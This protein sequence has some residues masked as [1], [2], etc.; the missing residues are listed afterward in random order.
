MLKI[1][2]LGAALIIIIATVS[3]GAYAYFNDVQTISGNKIAAG[4][5]ELTLGGD[6]VS[7]PLD[8]SNVQP[9]AWTT[10]HLADAALP[11]FNFD[12]KNTGTI[13]GELDVDISAI[14]NDENTR[15]SVELRSGDTTD[16]TN[17][18]GELGGLMKIAVWVDADK[19]G[20]WTTGDYYLNPA[21]PAAVY[22]SSPGLPDAAF[23]TVNSFD[24]VAFPK[25]VTLGHNGDAGN[26]MVDYVFPSSTDTYT[27]PATSKGTGLFT[28]NVAQSDGVKFDV[29]VKLT[30]SEGEP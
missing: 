16:G 9:I 10:D 8:I 20:K 24:S 5:L 6:P 3:V 12:I 11:A 29:T 26:L 19:D 15:S 7:H 14:E 27:D 4:T 22:Y 30:Q 1:L 2:G 25:L 17:T 23:A 18:N 28:D 21:G 13:E